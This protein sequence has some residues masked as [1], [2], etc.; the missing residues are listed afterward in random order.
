[1]RYRPRQGEHAESY[2]IAMRDTVAR[3]NLLQPDLNVGLPAEKVA[4]VNDQQRRL[5]MGG[6]PFGTD[7]APRSHALHSIAPVSF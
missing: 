4:A 5:F 7:A 2:D 3:Q 6:T 1:M